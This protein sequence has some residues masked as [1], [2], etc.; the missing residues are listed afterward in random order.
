LYRRNR[1]SARQL[2]RMNAQAVFSPPARHSKFI[3]DIA[4]IMLQMLRRRHVSL[5]TGTL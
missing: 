5:H 1:R 3:Q 4:D 2:Q